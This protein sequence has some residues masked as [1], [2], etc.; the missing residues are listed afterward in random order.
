[1]GEKGAREYVMIGRLGSN[2]RADYIYQKPVQVADSEIG[3][4][5]PIMGVEFDWWLN[6]GSG[7][8]MLKAV[9]KVTS[10]FLVHF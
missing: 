3:G 5:L 4:G 2:Q 6:E 8:T 9:R 7:G 10:A 1:M